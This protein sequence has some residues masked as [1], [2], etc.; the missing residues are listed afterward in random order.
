MELF[1]GGG[2]A[3]DVEDFRGGGICSVDCSASRGRGGSGG[4]DCLRD[5][6][7]GGLL[8]EIFGRVGVDEL[9]LVFRLEAPFRL[10]LCNSRAP[11]SS[12]DVD[13]EGDS[14]SP[15]L[16]YDW[17]IRC[18]FKSRFDF[19]VPVCVVEAEYID[20]FSLKGRGERDVSP[21]ARMKATGR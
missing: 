18:A 9:R 4:R 16:G 2:G 6:F 15:R 10:E 13:S 12:G 19:S 1:R 11:N 7:R 3:N 20:P 14:D 21:D 8:S 17:D 5:S